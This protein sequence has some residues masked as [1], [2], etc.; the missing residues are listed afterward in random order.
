[1]EN[2]KQTDSQPASK[3]MRFLKMGVIGGGVLI[4]IMSIALI[5]MVIQKRG[6]K[7]QKTEV[8]AAHPVAETPA[9][10]PVKKH[11][12]ETNSILT[13][14]IQGQ[15]EQMVGTPAGVA[16]WVRTA[17]GNEVVMLDA[18]G[19]LVRRVIIKPESP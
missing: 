12:V 7:S 6:D 15:V 2:E 5:V 14:P 17:A 10:I 16:V 4:L 3:S 19:N 1:M 9:P 13:L 8:K 11:M 18:A